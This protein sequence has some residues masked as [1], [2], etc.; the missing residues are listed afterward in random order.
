MSVRGG[1]GTETKGSRWG[2]GAFAAAAGD[3]LEVAF[4]YLSTDGKGFDD[5]AWA[6]L[7]G[8]AD[9]GL[10]AWLFTARSSN[11]STRNIVPGDVLSRQDFDPRSVIVDY[12]QFEFHSKTSADPV[13]WSP[14]GAS[15]GSCWKD[16]AAGCGYTGWLLSRHD[17]ASSGQYR[18]ELGVVNWGDGAYDSGLA[19]DLAGLQA[20]VPEPQAWVLLSVGLAAWVAGAT[21]RRRR[22]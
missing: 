15:N 4:N 21:R 10:V 19:F 8:A 22:H 2:S 12:D 17:F 20:P 5:Y 18:L 6:R 13:N 9:G 16:N 14:L 7:V 11:S 1:S 3:R